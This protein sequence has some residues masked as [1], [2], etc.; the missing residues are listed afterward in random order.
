MKI[1]TLIIEDEQDNIDILQHFLKKYCHQVEVVGEALSVAEAKTKIST[2][3]PDL[4]LLDIMLGESTGFDLLDT[5]KEYN[6]QVI[7][8]TAYND[9]AIK[10]FKYSAV[11]YLLKPV[12]IDD[13]IDAIG[14]VEEK[15]NH[16]FT[17]NQISA[18]SQVLNQESKVEVLAIP[19]VDKIEFLKIDDIMWIKA[20]R[21]YSLFTT[22]DNKNYI[23]SRNIGSYEYLLE[24]NRF[25]RA[26]HSFLI[27]LN[28]VNR[29]NK[30]DGLFFEMKDGEVIPISRRK[31]Q[32][33]MERLRL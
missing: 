2:L 21:K 28:W 24:D 27:N 19:M 1:R 22:S 30:G 18:L 8:I 17:S 12:Q 26:H 23:S 14:K 3:N 9:F 5:I 29:I 11:D 16:S 33:L 25:F 32:E 31:K 4:L 15:K 10:A 7:F 13:L 20:E 6:L